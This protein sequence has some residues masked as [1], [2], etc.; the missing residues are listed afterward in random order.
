[1]LETEN[2]KEKGFKMQEIKLNHELRLREAELLENESLLVK[3]KENL[4][5]RNQ[6]LYN[7]VKK[8][9]EDNLKQNEEVF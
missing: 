6:D 2:E 9:E 8:F 5:T 4:L 7:M 3:E 1:M